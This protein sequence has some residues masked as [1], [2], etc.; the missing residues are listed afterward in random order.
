M[1]PRNLQILQIHETNFTAIVQ[2]SKKLLPNGTKATFILSF[3]HFINAKSNLPKCCNKLK[4][5]LPNVQVGDIVQGVMRFASSD[6]YESG[7]QSNSAKKY[8]KWQPFEC[9]FADKKILKVIFTRHQ[10]NNLCTGQYKSIRQHSWTTF[11]VPPKNNVFKRNLSYD[12]TSPKVNDATIY[13]KSM[14]YHRS[15]C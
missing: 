4:Y 12:L 1:Y 14:Y 7:S 6:G 3:K 10:S 5:S 13:R 2:D 11:N 15:Y 9:Q 8:L